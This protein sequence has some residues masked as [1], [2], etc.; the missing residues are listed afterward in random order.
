MGGQSISLEMAR[1]YFFGQD[2]ETISL[3]MGKYFRYKNNN[4]GEKH[5]TK[6]FFILALELLLGFG[7]KK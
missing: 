7:G 5:V 1:E 2:R 3:P 4:P 6:R